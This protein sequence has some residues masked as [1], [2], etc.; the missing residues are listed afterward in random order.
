MRKSKFKKTQLLSFDYELYLSGEYNA[1][2]GD[3]LNESLDIVSFR[4]NKVIGW[5][6]NTN[7]A[8]VYERFVIA[9]VKRNPIVWVNVV[10]NRHGIIFSRVTN[11]PDTKPQSGNVMIKQYE[12]EIKD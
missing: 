8:F 4:D 11:T 10:K 12:L 3:N 2:H 6:T 9:L 1:Y 7:S 5:H